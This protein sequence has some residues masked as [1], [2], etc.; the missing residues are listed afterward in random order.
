MLPN[1]RMKHTCQSPLP[2]VGRKKNFQPATLIMC[3]NA[4][5]HT[6]IHN[7]YAYIDVQCITL[8]TTTIP[9]I[10]I[11]FHYR[12]FI[13]RKEYECDWIVYDCAR[14]RVQR[15]GHERDPFSGITIKEETG[16]KPRRISALMYCVS[17]FYWGTSR[18]Y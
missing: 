18:L 15:R 11:F 8:H 1:H 6:H 17:W 10:T 9:N 7:T 16:K 12:D 14:A 2:H 5:I 3:R 13:W 4:Y